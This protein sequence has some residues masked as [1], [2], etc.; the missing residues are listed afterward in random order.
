MTEKNWEISK[1]LSAVEERKGG[2]SSRSPL[3]YGYDLTLLFSLLLTVQVCHAGALGLPPNTARVGYGLGI[4]YSTFDDPVS[5]TNKAWTKTP[6]EIIYTDWFIGGS[7][8]W[9]DISHSEAVVDPAREHVGQIVKIYGAGLSIQTTLRFFQGWSP[10]IGG[11]LKLNHIDYKKRHTIDE[12]GYLLERFGNARENNL[13]VILNVMGEG[14]LTRNVSL[15]GK[16][17]QFF[18]FGEANRV[19]S[20]NITALYRF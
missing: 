9:A 13:G 15:G 6:L 10:W 19:L 7:R 20:F 4:S 2:S 5:S 14:S 1:T 17:E 3:S 16:I 12:D 18:A 8:F 11:G